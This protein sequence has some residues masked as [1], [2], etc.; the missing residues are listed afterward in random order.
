M[1]TIYFK[2]DM[3]YQAP[4]SPSDLSQTF[5]FGENGAWS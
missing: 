3:G 1:F 4:V 5:D 2:I